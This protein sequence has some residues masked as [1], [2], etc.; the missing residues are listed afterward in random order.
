MP[1]EV[2]LITSYNIYEVIF[3]K[4]REYNSY[5]KTI[6]DYNFQKIRFIHIEKVRFW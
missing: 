6:Y 2:F 4:E 3:L 5:N 1:E